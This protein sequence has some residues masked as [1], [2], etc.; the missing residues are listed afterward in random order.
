MHPNLS[1]SKN[2]KPPTVEKIRMGLK[3]YQHDLDKYQTLNL[4]DKKIV[5]GSKYFRKDAPSLN[6]FSVAN[7][8]K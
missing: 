5:E 8:G 2:R 1:K 3:D 4:L 7:E 6:Y